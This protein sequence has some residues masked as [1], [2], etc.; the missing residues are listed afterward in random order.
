ML[1][2]MGRQAG[3]LYRATDGTIEEVDRFFVPT[4][5]FSDNEGFFRARGDMYSGSVR[6]SQKAYVFQEM[7]KDVVSSLKTWRVYSKPDETYVFAPA[8][9]MYEILQRVKKTVGNT[10]ARSY[11]GHYVQA[12]PFD[13]LAMIADERDQ[14]VVHLISEEALQLMV[15]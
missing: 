14:R 2:V 3:V 13:L 9:L 11:C 7:M 8:H 12:H 6:E 5:K 15:R 1:L 10:Y 4:P